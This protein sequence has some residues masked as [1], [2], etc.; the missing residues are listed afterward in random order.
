MSNNK[1]FN[2]FKQSLI[3][4]NEKNY[5]AEIREKYG[6]QAV[7]E[8]NSKLMG[9]TQEQYDEGE[10]LRLAF[11]ETLKAAF[12]TG[13]PAGELAQNA[14]DFH[15][16]WLCIFYPNYNKEYHKALG[17]MYVADERFR[18]NYDKLGIGCTEFLRDAINIWA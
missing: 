15:R 18:V 12:A 6:D 8:S 5:G 10:R 2:D 7:D 14:C 1:E 3:D 11:E 9:L 16:Q 4:G 17:E 13:D